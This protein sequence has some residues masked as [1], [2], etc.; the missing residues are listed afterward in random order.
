MS[1]SGQPSPGFSHSGELVVPLFP[2]PNVVLFPKAVLPLHI[3]EERYKTMTRDAIAGDRRI[4][5]ALLKPGWEKQYYGRPAIEP[6]VCVGQMLS[7]EE[8]PDGRFN[9][10]LRGSMRARVVRELGGPAADGESDKPY[11]LAVLEPL[12]D[13]VADPSV[14]EPARDALR[15]IFT[16]SSLAA[17]PMGR[18]FAELVN[19][20]VPVNDLADLVAFNFLDE[21]PLKQQL[22]AETDVARRLSLLVRSLRAVAGPVGTSNARFAR[23]SL[24]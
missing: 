4:A 16:E 11:R 18:K 22:L 1:G 7:H 17:S 5:M 21:I 14:L 3:F 8:L 2:L 13:R 10:L 15:T 24:N 12:E 6:V 19:G 20:P 9:F 23:P